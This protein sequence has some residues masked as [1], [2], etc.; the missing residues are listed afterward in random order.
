VPPSPEQVQATM[1]AFARVGRAWM[2]NVSQETRVDE[3]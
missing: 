3:H 1:D 2:T